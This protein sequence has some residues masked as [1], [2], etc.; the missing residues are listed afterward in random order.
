MW[1]HPRGPGELWGLGG[2]RGTLSAGGTA[3]AGELTPFSSLPTLLTPVCLKGRR[4]VTSTD[5]AG[6]GEVVSVA[7]VHHSQG[8]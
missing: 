5:R 1:T 7:L 3:W 4:V 8:W 6:G 2:G